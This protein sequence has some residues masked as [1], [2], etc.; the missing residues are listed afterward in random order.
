[1]E[2]ST[3]QTLLCALQVAKSPA[4]IRMAC[5]PGG[6]LEAASSRRALHSRLSSSRL[7]A[8]HRSLQG[9]QHISSHCRAQNV[10]SDRLT[11]RRRSQQVRRHGD[12]LQ[13]SCTQGKSVGISDVPPW[14]LDEVNSSRASYMCRPPVSETLQAKKRY[15]EQQRTRAQKPSNARGPPPASFAALGE[16]AAQQAGSRQ[17]A[18]EQQSLQ[19]RQQPPPQETAP[20]EPEAPEHNWYGRCLAWL[21]AF[22]EKR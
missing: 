1:M 14:C 11:V 20:T 3:A 9:L 15:R 19:Q 17:A 18:S 2:C 12:L 8:S 7:C 5:L 4:S 6:G 22:L 16:L 10:F 21:L 13:E